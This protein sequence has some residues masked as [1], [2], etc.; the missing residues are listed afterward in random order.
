MGSS[1]KY[2]MARFSSAQGETHPG[3]HCQRE[4][5]PLSVAVRVPLPSGPTLAPQPSTKSQAKAK[6][7][8]I[9][10]SSLAHA[11]PLSPLRKRDQAALAEYFER[12]NIQEIALDV[13]RYLA[14]IYPEPCWE[15]E[16]WDF[17]HASAAP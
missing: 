14:Q 3:S 11:S 8:I 15:D 13:H 17:L 6:L 4:Y 1:L 7:R 12:E 5:K 10:G 2:L 16:P 9:H